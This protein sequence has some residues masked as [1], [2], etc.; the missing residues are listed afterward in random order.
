[1]STLSTRRS[2]EY[3]FVET[4]YTTFIDMRD[5]TSI[6]IKDAVLLIDQPRIEASISEIFGNRSGT[7]VLNVSIPV[8][9]QL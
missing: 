9:F 6:F 7:F 2:S 8:L 4:D 3:I 5:L 1:M